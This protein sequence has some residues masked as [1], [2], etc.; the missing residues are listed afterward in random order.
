MGRL[1]SL[2]VFYGPILCCIV[3]V[4]HWFLFVIEWL[5]PDDE[6]EMVESSWTSEAFEEVRESS[7]WGDGF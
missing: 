3:A 2:G 5:W 1:L 6:I 4:Q 7:D